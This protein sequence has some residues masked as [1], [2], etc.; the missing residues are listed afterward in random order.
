[1]SHLRKHIL[2]ILLTSR[3]NLSCQ[4][5]ITSSRQFQALEINADF[6]RAGIDHFFQTTPSRWIRFY[7]IGEPTTAFGKMIELTEYARC[8]AGPALTVEVQTNGLFDDDV[9]EWFADQVDFTY[10]SFD[11][12][13]DVHDHY[14]RTPTGDLVSELV[15]QRIRQLKARQRFVSVRATITQHNLYRQVE[16]IDFLMSLGIDCAFSKPVLTPLGQSSTVPE[17]PIMEYAREYLAAFRYADERGFFYGSGLMTG[18]DEKSTHY[19]R[20]HIPAAH[21]TPDGYVSSCDRA[22]WGGTPLQDLI[23]GKWNPITRSIDLD[24]DRI[25]A[26]RARSLA[27]LPECRA[28]PVGPYCCGN[29]V[30]TAYQKT[31]RMLDIVP[32]YCAA[33]KYLYQEMQWKRGLFPYFHP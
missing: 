5:C 28:C 12:L 24:Q 13:P 32:E 22:F 21:L 2:S 19:C 31:G 29:C 25:A 26:I 17:V 8:I 30:G 16:M 3:C 23:Y 1:M 18:F 33:I 10:V 4:Y 7:S 15:L 14:R 9:L 11:G 20:A 6:A 27:N